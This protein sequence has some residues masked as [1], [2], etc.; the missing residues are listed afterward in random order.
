MPVIVYTYCNN[1]QINRYY[2]YTCYNN[3]M[4]GIMKHTSHNYCIFHPVWNWEWWQPCTLFSLKYKSFCKNCTF[5]MAI[6][7]FKV[8]QWKWEYRT[9]DDTTNCSELM[10]VCF[11][12]WVTNIMKHA[13]YIDNVM[14]KILQSLLKPTCSLITKKNLFALTGYCATD[15][16][17]TCFVLY[18]KI[19]N[20]C[21]KNNICILL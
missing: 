10:T 9:L 1:L 12:V 15:Q 19:I 17:L 8:M 13:F 6:W 21:E 11:T 16:E 5:S 20:T 2:T 14:S 4:H 18:F 7:R 3:Y